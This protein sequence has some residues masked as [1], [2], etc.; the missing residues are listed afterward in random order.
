[1]ECHRWVSL[2]VVDSELYVPD[3][4]NPEFGLIYDVPVGFRTPFLQPP[5]KATLSI[6]GMGNIEMSHHFCECLR[7]AYAAQKA[8]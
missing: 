3:E 1:M 4:P 2:R 7:S 6:T 8:P 5:R